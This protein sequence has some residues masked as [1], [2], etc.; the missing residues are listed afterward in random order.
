MRSG[1]DGLSR[2][3]FQDQPAVAGFVES[4]AIDGRDNTVG[5]VLWF[6]QGLV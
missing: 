5:I 4:R 6:L 1:M 3:A 2:T